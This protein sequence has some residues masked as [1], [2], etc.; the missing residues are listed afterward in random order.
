MTDC[1][2]I[3]GLHEAAV[4]AYRGVHDFRKRLGTRLPCDGRAV[5]FD[6]ALADPEIGS[7]VLAGVS[8]PD[9]VEDLTLACGQR[10][11]TLNGQ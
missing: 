10:L 1:G 9:E 11:D 5:V 4:R 3:P 6:C 8:H 2:S 7:N